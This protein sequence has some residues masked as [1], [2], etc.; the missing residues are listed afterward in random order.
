M[1]TVKEVI[2]IRNGKEVIEGACLSSDSKPST[3]GNGSIAIEMDTSK[4]FLFD[5][6]NRTWREWE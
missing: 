5:E 4:L 6:T 3:F 2:T 1:F